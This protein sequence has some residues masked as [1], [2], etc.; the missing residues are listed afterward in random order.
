MFSMDTRMDARTRFVVEYS[1]RR[2]SMYPPSTRFR[3]LFHSTSVESF[4][5]TTLVQGA[6]LGGNPQAGFPAA[7]HS[8]HRG[9]ERE[10]G[11]QRTR[12]PGLEGARG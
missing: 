12:L 10:R 1:N 2:I 4:S 3:P 5:T 8:G 7:L 11:S 6:D 9:G